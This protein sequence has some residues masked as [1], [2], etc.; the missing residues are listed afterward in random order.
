MSRVYPTVEDA[1]ATHDFLIEEYG[2][3]PGIRDKG[4][5]E[6]AIFRP[7]SGYYNS[8]IEE[9]AALMES[10]G[11]N[12]PFIDGNK[13]AAFGVCDGFLRSNGYYIDC[14]SIAAHEKI[15]GMFSTNSFNF[16]N[17]CAWLGEIVRQKPV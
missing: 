8:I 17:L 6:S 4:A 3:S 16:L 7:Q 12:H 10:L 13:R 11:G 14:D 2:G 1:I 15:M 5:L 9:A